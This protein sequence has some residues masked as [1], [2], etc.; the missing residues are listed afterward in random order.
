MLCRSCSETFEWAEGVEEDG[1]V[2]FVPFHSRP[3]RLLAER[4]TDSNIEPIND[5]QFCAFLVALVTSDRVSRQSAGA[6]IPDDPNVPL[7]GKFQ[8]HLSSEKSYGSPYKCHYSYEISLQRGKRNDHGR[9][10][11]I[12]FELEGRGK[13]LLFGSLIILLHDR[14]SNPID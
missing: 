11:L 8:P 12:L 1:I 7:K 5:C 9:A 13:D 4:R 3:W 10:P 2:A 6:L 14:S